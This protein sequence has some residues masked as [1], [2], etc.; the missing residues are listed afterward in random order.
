MFYTSTGA[1]VRVFEG[2][3]GVVNGVF[4]KVLPGFYCEFQE[5]RLV[6]RAPTWHEDRLSF[7]LDRTPKTMTIHVLPRAQRHT[8]AAAAAAILPCCAARQPHCALLVEEEWQPSG[9]GVKLT[10]L[11]KHLLHQPVP[12]PPRRPIRLRHR[13]RPLPFPAS[14]PAP[15]RGRGREVC[16]K[17]I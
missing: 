4:T 11:L 3:Q 16:D 14:P 6:D 1:F 15:A 10:L 12:L 13:L 9:E 5:S 8:G 17:S 7:T 2:H